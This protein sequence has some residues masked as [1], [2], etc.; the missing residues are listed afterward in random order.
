LTDEQK[1]NLVRDILDKEITRELLF[2]LGKKNNKVIPP[3]R[4][5][6]ELDQLKA[7]YPDQR[8]FEDAL[9]QRDINIDVLRKS[10]EVDL[11]SR[12]LLEEQV[13][14]KIQIQDES[15][16]KYY[17]ENKGRF[18]R[19]EA[20][21]AQHIF[22]YHFPPT[23]EQ[24]TPADKLEAKKAELSA[25]AEKRI[26]EIYKEVKAL[27][28][29]FAAL[30]KK[31]SQDEGSAPSGGDLEFIYKGVFPP[32][33][34]AAAAKLKP[35]EVSPIVRTDYGY[36]IIKFNE[37]KPPELA[38]YEEM[39]DAIRQYLYIEEAKK[40]VNGYIDGVKKDSKIEVF[41]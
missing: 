37:S 12:E 26:K 5:D 22:L 21:R 39:K 3:Q 32:E 19:P 1:K 2:Q 13:R 40:I 10:V 14:D 41:Y 33:F 8:T 36:H 31:Y 4:V 25:Q 30:A 23:I 35:G 7:S 6:D 18:Q 16:K 9:K 28:H 11:V 27:K 29:D 20:Y 17:D 24:T 15:A 34:D 38:P